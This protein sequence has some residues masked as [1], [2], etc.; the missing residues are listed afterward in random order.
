MESFPLLQ[1]RHYLQL[2]MFVLSVLGED[3]DHFSDETLIRLLERL[4]R[5]LLEPRTILLQEVICECVASVVSI[6]QR[7]EVY[8]CCEECESD[9]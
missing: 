9:L 8:V 2:L 4:V 6:L 1:F 7:R 3:R 5:C